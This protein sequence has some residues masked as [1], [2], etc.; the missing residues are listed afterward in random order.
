M[1]QRRT[2]RKREA[3]EDQWAEALP[4]KGKEAAVEDEST[5]DARE[6][7]E[8]AARLLERDA[9]KTKFLVDEPPEDRSALAGDADQRRA[10]LPKIREQSRQAYLQ[11]REGQKLQSLRGQIE[12][13]AVFANVPLTEAEIRRSQ[14][15]RDVLELAERH[16]SIDVKPQVYQM[17]DSSQS[18]GSNWLT[19]RVGLMDD[20]GMMDAEKRGGVL[21]KRSDDGGR[22]INEQSVWE[23]TQI[24][25]MTQATER[26]NDYEFVLEEE[27]ETGSVLEGDEEQLPYVDPEI[28]KQRSILETRRSLPIFGY[29]EELI[30]AVREHQV[31]IIVGETGSGKTTQIP[32][33][34]Y[35]EGFTK[36][37]KKIGCTQPRR[38]AAMSVA[39]RVSEEMRTRIGYEVGYSIRFEDCTSKRTVIKY[40]TDGM[41]LREFLTEPDLASYSC[42]IIDEAHERT[43]HTDILFGLVKDIARYRPDLKLLISSATLDAE[44]FSDFFDG[45][46]IFTIPGRR[47]PVDILYTKAPEADYVA[48]TIATVMQIHMTQPLGDILIFLTGQE[49]IETVQE[50]LMLISKHLGKKMRELIIA[51]IYSSLPSEMQGQIFNATPKGAR[52]VV[53]AT[54]IAETSITIDGIVYVIDPGFCKQKTFSPKT[55]M[56]SLIV[57]PCSK[58]SANQ[59][60]GRAGRVGPGKC[61]RLY[62]A[63]AYENELEDN[64]T[65]EIQRTN[66]ANVVLLLKSL[67]IND[68]LNFDFM[69]KPS[70]DVLMQALA[71][72]YALGALNDRGELTKTGRRMAEFPLDPMMSKALLASEK[73]QCSEEIASIMAMLSIQ[74]AIFYRPKEKKIQA[75]AARKMLS[76]PFGDHMTLLNIW[77][78][79]VETGFDSN[80][81]Y[82]NFIQIK[83]MKRARDVRDQIINLMGRVEIVLQSKP[84]DNV[85]IRKAIAAGYFAN[86]GRLQ[87][88]GEAYNSVKQ[89]QTIHIHPSSGL[90]QE[91]PRWVIYHELVL[92]AREYMRQVM[93]IQPEWLMEAAPHYFSASELDDPSKRKL[94]RSFGKAAR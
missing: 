23:D 15:Q 58:A 91:N 86:A 65:P 89:S 38:V 83:S 48:A 26:E 79:W 22:R 82:D 8:F 10:M 5:Q 61:F 51:P 39:A 9:K 14:L 73:F 76:V 11:M 25:K 90:F 78:S 88:S 70:E 59:R 43:L 32:Q 54:N 62:T 18:S 69:D 49:E 74:G 53:L 36:G 93:E 47:Y 12:A 50:N 60:A 72:L 7:E 13:E 27:F 21:K 45:A 35:E 1:S 34:L 94:P 31:L 17:P 71:Q 66:L 56:E 77:S 52:K 37:Q 85:A 55:G 68:L 28:A 4:E 80:W 44:K 24:G 42:L 16:R 92:T 6:V 3:R 33:Y 75:D 41:L 81:C 40:M 29:R 64:T 57:T 63:W 84:D 20:E 46:P 30:E 87:M 2:A 67:G 19:N